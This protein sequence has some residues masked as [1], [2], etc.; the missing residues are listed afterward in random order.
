M[1]LVLVVA[2]VYSDRDIS[3][4]SDISALVI[5]TLVTLVILV[6]L[7]VLCSQYGHY[8]LVGCRLLQIIAAVRNE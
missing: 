1:I 8:Q 3:G 5:V 7:M 2:L 6:M 4:T